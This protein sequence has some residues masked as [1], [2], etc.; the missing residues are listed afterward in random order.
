MWKIIIVKFGEKVIYGFGFGLGMGL[1]FKALSIKNI[2]GSEVYFLSTFL[3]QEIQSIDLTK[4]TQGIYFLEILVCLVQAY[5]F[6]LLSAVFIG[7]A[8]HVQH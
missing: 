5:V 4:L 6:S 3:T 2:K 1:S 8:I 7:M